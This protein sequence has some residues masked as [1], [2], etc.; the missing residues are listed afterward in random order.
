MYGYN[1]FDDLVLR[2]LSFTSYF[3]LRLSKNMS[4]ADSQFGPTIVTKSGV[5]STSEAL[6]G[7]KLIGL[8]FSAHWCP[9]CRGFTPVLSEFYDTLKEEDADALEII[10]V[11]SDSDQASFE[12]YYHSMPWSAVPFSAADIRQ[13]LG[14]K[15]SVRGI[16]A[17]IILKASDGSVKDTDG[18]TT[19][20]SARGDTTK[21]L[22]KWA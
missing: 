18:R 6:A 14:Q 16:P 8:Y 12:E 21:A 15:H 7:K 17:F 5:K 10:F 3:T 20:I 22:A 2:A 13:S 9:P 19:V 4:W 1:S 11:S